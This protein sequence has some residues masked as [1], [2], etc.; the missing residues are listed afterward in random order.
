MKRNNFQRL[1]EEETKGAPPLSPQIKNNVQGNM[2]FFQFL[3]KTIDLYLPKILDALVASL[4]GPEA[5]APNRFGPSKG[6]T[7]VDPD[8]PGK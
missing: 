2:G 4:S 6:R 3:G 1:L 7:P 8:S 5:P